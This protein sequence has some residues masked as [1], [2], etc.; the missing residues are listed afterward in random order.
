MEI[1]DI[2]TRVGL[3]QEAFADRYHIPLQTLKQWESS[4]GSKSY[5]K[6][7]EYVNY[8]LECLVGQD[9]NVRF[10]P[11]T[12]V[13]NLTVAAKHSHSCL[14]QWL[15]YLGKEFN[16]HAVRLTEEQV[17]TLLLSDDISM[18]QKAAFMMVMEDG[19]ALN[20]YVTSLEQKARTPMVDILVKGLKQ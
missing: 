6:P 3:T 4:P 10:G 7:P 8:M 16:S 18:V 5:R 9:F 15:R 12:R 14:R 20:R 11:L 17:R 2:R 19:T 1:R 13:E